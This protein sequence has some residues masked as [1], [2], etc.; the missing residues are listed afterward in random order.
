VNFF[1]FLLGMGGFL[2][3]LGGLIE[4]FFMKGKIHHDVALTRMKLGIGA[5]ILSVLLLMS[6]VQ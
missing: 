2:S 3:C 1:V 5:I 6:G 4:Y